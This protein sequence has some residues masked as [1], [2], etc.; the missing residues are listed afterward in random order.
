MDLNDVLDRLTQL[1]FRLQRIE[2]ELGLSQEDVACFDVEPNVTTTAELI[3]QLDAN[4]LTIGS[5]RALSISSGL[6]RVQSRRL[7]AVG[8]EKARNEQVLGLLDALHW[9]RWS[10]LDGKG[11]IT[12]MLGKGPN[13]LEV[14]QSIALLMESLKSQIDLSLQDDSGPMSLNLP[15]LNEDSDGR[16]QQLRQRDTAVL[17]P[18]TR[19]VE[20][21]VKDPCF[22]WS[23]T[24]TGKEWSGR[25]DGLEICRLNES[26]QGMLHLGKGV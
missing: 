26:G 17:P 7:F 21:K 3:R 13:L 20:A 24:L 2:G 15:D 25:I 11:A 19:T 12:Y 14:R 5:D 8:G 4:D 9:H 1:E 22:R 10:P 6:I 16:L 18:L 23:R